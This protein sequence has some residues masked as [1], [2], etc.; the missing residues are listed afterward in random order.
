MS[1]NTEFHTNPLAPS[2]KETP[3]TWYRYRRHTDAVTSGQTRVAAAATSSNMDASTSGRVRTAAA[4]TADD[5]V[6]V[7]ISCNWS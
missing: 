1:R 2:A 6:M 5:G 7:S 4:A 3:H